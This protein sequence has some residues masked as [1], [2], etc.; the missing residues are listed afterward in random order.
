[1][2]DA[3]ILSG[4][5]PSEQ[6]ATGER[7]SLA[8]G[9]VISVLGSEIVV[10]EIWCNRFNGERWISYSTTNGQRHGCMAAALISPNTPG[11]REAR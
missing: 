5:A 10:T 3:K 4:I 7:C 9:S 1:M 8:V 6:R 11:S 2:N